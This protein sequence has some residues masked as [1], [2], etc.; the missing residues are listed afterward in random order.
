MD[1]KGKVLEFLWWAQKQGLAYETIR[2]YR[3]CLR[4]LM[5]KVPTS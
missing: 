4:A 3:S 1:V 5:K 2:G